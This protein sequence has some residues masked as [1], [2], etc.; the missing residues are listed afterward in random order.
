MEQ[1]KYRYYKGG[2]VD[3]ECVYFEVTDDI[4]RTTTCVVNVPMLIDGYINTFPCG[5]GA[6]YLLS[7][8]ERLEILETVERG[9]KPY[10]EAKVKTLDGWRASGISSFQDYCR[11]GDIVDET[12]V[13]YFVDSVPPH[14]TRAS[15][16]QAGESYSLEKDPKTGKYRNTWTTFH[17]E[18]V[19]IFRYDGACFTGEN[20]HRAGEMSKLERA[21]KELRGNRA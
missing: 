21:I 11:P 17:R 13:E 19:G 5:S 1:I 14:L 18:G 20:V 7:T 6:D 16:T 8:Q 4:Y 2:K 12:I 10:T 15:C 9:R 3:R